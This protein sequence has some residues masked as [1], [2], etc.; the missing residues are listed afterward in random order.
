MPIFS[1]STVNRPHN[2][3]LWTLIKVRW[4]CLLWPQLFGIAHWFLIYFQSTVG[5]TLRFC[6]M[7]CC[8]GYHSTQK[9]RYCCIQWS[10]RYTEITLIRVDIYELQNDSF[11]LNICNRNV[12]NGIRREECRRL[13]Q[14]SE[15]VECPPPLPYFI[16]FIQLE[17]GT[18]QMSR[19][20]TSFFFF[21]FKKRWRW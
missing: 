13:V 14:Y 20:C 10:S 2:F 18:S 5:F 6:S 9:A 19:S 4:L 21:F 1:K 11:F 12:W 16:Y 3:P 7:Y 8:S 15:G 17:K